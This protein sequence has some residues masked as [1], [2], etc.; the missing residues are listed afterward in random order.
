MGLR[1]MFNSFAVLFVLI[2]TLLLLVHSFGPLHRTQR[3]PLYRIGIPGIIRQILKLLKYSLISI[4]QMPLLLLAFL[5]L[6]GLVLSFYYWYRQVEMG[7]A[8]TLGL[9][10]LTAVISLG[11][12]TLLLSPIL[13]ITQRL[14]F[15]YEIESRIFRI[16]IYSVFVPFLYIFIIQDLTPGPLVEGIMLTG[17]AISF[18]Q[19]FKGIIFCL[20]APGAVFYHWDSRFIPVLMIIS[21]LLVI[22]FNLYTMILLVSNTDPYS[23]VDGSGPVTE[24]LRLLY[25]TV[26]TFTSVGYGDITPRG[27]FAV[28][29]AILVSVTGFLYSALFI[30]GILAAFTKRNGNN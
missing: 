14:L 24:P 1:E 3:K 6:Y 10:I 16:A 5:L 9:S 26:I 28:F 18:Y 7:L 11:L 19:I 12:V 30:G 15:D 17:L 29:I 25:F 22:I 20:Q 4:A 2:G 27:S 21:W 8:G 23:F 13:F